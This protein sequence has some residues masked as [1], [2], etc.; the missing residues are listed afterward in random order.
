MSGLALFKW[1]EEFKVGGG[2]DSANPLLPLIG[3]AHGCVFGALLPGNPVY[4]NLCIDGNPNGT[5]RHSNDWKQ[6]KYS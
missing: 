3:G 4:R 5:Y 1:S 2:K 6:V